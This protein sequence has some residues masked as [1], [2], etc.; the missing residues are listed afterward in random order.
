M[1]RIEMDHAGAVAS[2]GQ[3]GES[4]DLLAANRLIIATLQGQAQ[5]SLLGSAK[6][7]YDGVHI[8]IPIF[9]SS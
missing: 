2:T 6:I 9:K 7:G 1:K 4:V 3:S 8:W 5:F